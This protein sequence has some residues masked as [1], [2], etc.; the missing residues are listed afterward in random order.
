MPKCATKTKSF[1]GAQGDTFV[2]A[3]DDQQVR[4]SNCD[5]FVLHLLQIQAPV[6]QMLHVLFAARFL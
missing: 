3:T 6:A 4:F 1:G 5:R 2:G